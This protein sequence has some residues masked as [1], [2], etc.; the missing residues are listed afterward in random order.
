[1]FNQQICMQQYNMHKTGTNAFFE[2]KPHTFMVCLCNLGPHKC[3][4]SPKSAT[5]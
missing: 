4:H 2:T 1:M 3:M 5:Y